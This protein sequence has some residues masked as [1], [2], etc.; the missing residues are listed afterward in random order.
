ML[1]VILWSDCGQQ[2]T[3]DT[4]SE[5][6]LTSDP[7]SLLPT[8][9]HGYKIALRNMEIPSEESLDGDASQRTEQNRIPL[10]TSDTFQS[11]ALLHTLHEKGLDK[12]TMSCDAFYALSALCSFVASSS[13]QYLNLLADLLGKEQV[14]LSEPYLEDSDVILHRLKHT[15]SC[16]MTHAAKLAAT[17]TWIESRGGSRCKHA[18]PGAQSREAAI[19]ESEAQSILCDFKYLADRSQQL[20]GQCA[21]QTELL[22]NRAALDTARR[23]VLQGQAI[24][25][26]TLLAFLFLPLGIT[27]SFFGMNF[28]EL[29][30]KGQEEAMLGIWVWFLVSVPVFLI[31]V[32]YC[33]WTTVKRWVTAQLYRSYLL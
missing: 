25:G 20:L 23:G 29:A 24:E 16:L 21:E 1:A 11:A 12:K 9:R 19:A 33:F 28:K 15:Q 10:L 4:L 22:M 14:R 32:L 31:S 7:V 8:Y 5:W 3:Q 2:I 13:S 17:L 18:L 30:G 27:T 26:L 6:L